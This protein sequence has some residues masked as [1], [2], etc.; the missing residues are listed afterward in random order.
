MK[1]MVFIFSISIFSFACKGSSPTL[2]PLPEPAY[3]I[4]GYGNLHSLPDK[5]GN[6]SFAVVFE[7]R[8]ENLNDASFT[9]EKGMLKDLIL[10]PEHEDDPHRTVFIVFAK[11]MPGERLIVKAGRTEK[12]FEFPVRTIPSCRWR[13][14]LPNL[15]YYKFNTEKQTIRN[16]FLWGTMFW[17]KLADIVFQEGEGRPMIIVNEG[18]PKSNVFCDVCN[19][20]LPDSDLPRLKQTASHEIGHAIGLYHSPPEEGDR[21]L[22]GGVIGDPEP[23]Y[24]KTYSIIN[25][26]DYF[27]SPSRLN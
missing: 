8:L 22:M 18:S 6:T 25:E 11:V 14:V 4:E 10:D 19:I 1:K 12:T 3:R 9:F 13:N 16:N 20:W 26:F 17:N 15:V 27:V 21:S 5:A 23:E 24:C 2:P 7:P